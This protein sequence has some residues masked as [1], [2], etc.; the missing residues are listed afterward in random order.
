VIDSYDEGT[1]VEGVN[2]TIHDNIISILL[3]TDLST[4]TSLDLRFKANFTVEFLNV[5]DGFWC[6][7][8]LVEGTRIR[9]RDYKLKVTDGPADLLLLYFGF[10]D[11]T[12]YHSDLVEN[13]KIVSALNRPV[14]VQNMNKSD[15]YADTKPDPGEA[16]YGVEYVDGITINILDDGIVTYYLFRDDIDIITVRYRTIH[17]LEFII[18]DNIKVPKADVRVN[19]YYGG[20]LYGAKISNV[21][22]LPIA[23]Q[24]SDSR[25]LVT[26]YGVPV[27]NYTI[28]I[29][30]ANSLPIEIHEV[31]SLKSAG[32]NMIVT[33]YTHF[34][35]TILVFL[36]ISVLFIVSGS[37]IFK[38][39]KN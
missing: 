35:S 20:L 7:D 16:G 32:D 17:N 1:L 27:G 12:I 14:A 5:V 21:E 11:T 19:V 13:S 38:K 34:P 39:N 8:R 23:P 31:S 15:P 26:I 30:D 25:G 2:Y 28:E 18:T 10:N 24:V 6:E 29:I 33:A 36:G 37:V 9:E 3:W 4:P 22:N